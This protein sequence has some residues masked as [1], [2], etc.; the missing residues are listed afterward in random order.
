MLRK[1]I[2][3]LTEI[4]YTEIKLGRTEKGK[5]FLQN[6]LPLSLKNLSFNVSHQ[7]DLVVLAA[8][9]AAV[10]GIDV[11]KLDT[12]SKCHKKFNLPYST[13][14]LHYCPHRGGGTYCF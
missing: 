14:L 1:V 2:S 12:P 7:G 11:M 5:P 8:E 13:L 6:D 10:V 4:P 3:D 9:E